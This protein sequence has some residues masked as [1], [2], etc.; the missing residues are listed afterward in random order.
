[1]EHDPKLN[2]KHYLDDFSNELELTWKKLAVIE[3]LER[4]LAD[5]PNRKDATSRRPAEFPFGQYGEGS[6]L[7]WPI[8]EP[9][10]RAIMD[11]FPATDN[12]VGFKVV[13][14]LNEVSSLNTERII[15]HEVFKVSGSSDP[16]HYTIT[17]RPTP[18]QG[19]PRRSPMPDIVAWAELY[20]LLNGPAS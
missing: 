3:G 15:M 14:Q 9:G 13:Y 18:L 16:E 8:A 1:M 4:L 20:R 5:I 6:R 2:E 12:E 19:Q 11:V 7:P 17:H 10:C